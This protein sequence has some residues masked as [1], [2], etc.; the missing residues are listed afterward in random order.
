MKK[1]L[2]LLFLSNFFISVFSQ[3][4]FNFCKLINGYWGQWEC[5]NPYQFIEGG[6]LM[7]GTYDE[8]IIYEYGKHPSQYIMKVK[9]FA[10]RVEQDKKIKKKRIKSGEWYQYTG[11]IEYY[12]TGVLERFNDIIQQWPYVPNSSNGKPH[13]VAAT[14]KIQPYK[15][16]PETYNIFFENMG[17][18]IQI[19]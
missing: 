19:K 2:L 18:G 17:L 4:Y 8:F 3:T 16:K 14:I 1:I 9:L 7:Q 10:M 5:S 11:S 6:Y 13:T 15:K 12:T